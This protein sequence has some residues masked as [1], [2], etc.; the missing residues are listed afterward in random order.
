MKKTIYFVVCRSR[1]DE[2]TS[3]VHLD[4]KSAIASAQWEYAC[5]S[6][7]D[8]K[9]SSYYVEGYSLDV[10][11]LHSLLAMD[12]DGEVVSPDFYTPIEDTAV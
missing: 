9:T 8:K 12:S 5:L 4:E 10:G 11:L 7:F 6:S 1:G 3:S 2:F